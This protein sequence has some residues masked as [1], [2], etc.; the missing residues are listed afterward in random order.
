MRR[1][2]E[3]VGGLYMGLIFIHSV[4]TTFE[5]Y[6]IYTQPHRA[7]CPED[8]VELTALL[9]AVVLLAGHGAAR[10]RHAYFS[11][12]ETTDSGRATPGLFSGRAL[13]SPVCSALIQHAAAEAH[14]YISEPTANAIALLIFYTAACYTNTLSLWSM[15]PFPQVAAN[16]ATPTTEANRAAP[17]GPRGPGG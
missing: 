1:Q 2:N 3:S 4:L 8:I 10:V 13:T 6:R 12:Q 15:G 16:P 17:Q 5:H 11:G 14:R 9:M 7:D